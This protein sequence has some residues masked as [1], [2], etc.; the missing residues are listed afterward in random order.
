MSPICFCRL[1]VLPLCL[2]LLAA[3]DVFARLPKSDDKV[4]VAASATKPDADGNQVVTLTLDIEKPWHLY[5]N[6]V[7]NDDLA[8]SQVVVAINAK[9][10]PESVKIDYPEGKVVKD[11][12]VGNYKI[13][14]D[15]V[16]IKAQVR[17]SK[18]DSGPLEVSIKLQ[19][20]S[21]KGCLLPATV[22]VQVP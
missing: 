8:D 17:R 11:A 22:K 6:P 13:Y 7:G 15:K 20:C 5:A 2:A 4:K 10:K 14:E 19:A 12:A 1:A 21:D 16:T 3:T 9:V 18:G